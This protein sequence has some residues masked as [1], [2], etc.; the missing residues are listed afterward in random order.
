M[1]LFVRSASKLHAIFP[2]LESKN[3]L[4]VNI[5]TGIASDT[6]E[7]SA[8]LEN[9]DVVFACIGS[10]Y[11]TYGQSIIRDTAA[12]VIDALESLRRKSPINRN[13]TWKAP[14]VIQL[15]SASLNPA[16]SMM[17]PWY[18]R[19]MAHFCFYYNYADLDRASAL[20]ASAAD[21]AS[22]LLQYILVDPPSIH[23]PQ[24]TQATGYRLILSDDK[25][26]KQTPVLSYAD[27]GVA[28]CECAERREELKGREVGVS[29]T[30]KVKETWNV[31]IWYILAGAKGRIWS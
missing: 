1:N 18:G 27:L 7:L 25:D 22:P 28:F 19:M 4:T 23:D 16:L 21:G 17:V 30:G 9:A 11:S 31:L 6:A 20:L 29:A 24:G 12:A 10:N 8:C 14:T 2:D 13:G 15:R 5:F 3:G 26:L